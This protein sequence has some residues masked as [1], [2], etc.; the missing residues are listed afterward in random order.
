MA[1]RP[2]AGRFRAD[3]DTG[4]SI[5]LDNGKVLRLEPDQSYETEDPGELEVLRGSGD[6]REMESTEKK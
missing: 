3:R 4:V 2:K 5:F 1:K 6:V